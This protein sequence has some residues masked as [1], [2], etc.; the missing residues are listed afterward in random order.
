MDLASLLQYV[1][2]DP[3]EAVA[4]PVVGIAWFLRLQWAVEGQVGLFPGRRFPLLDSWAAEAAAAIG[5]HRHHR[6]DRRPQRTVVG[7]VSAGLPAVSSVSTD[8]VHDSDE[9]VS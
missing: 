6:A 2:R 5:W 7:V 3:R 4:A 8:S 9:E 1:G